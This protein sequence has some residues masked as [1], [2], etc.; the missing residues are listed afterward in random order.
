MA[1]HIPQGVF[2]KTHY[3]NIENV[4]LELYRL[5]T[6]FFS[7]KKFAELRTDRS[8]CSITEIQQFEEV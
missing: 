7:S 6:I 5:L 3:T 4:H 8:G 1:E 2:T